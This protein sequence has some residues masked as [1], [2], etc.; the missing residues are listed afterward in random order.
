MVDANQTIR[1]R[2]HG[3]PCN[4]MIKMKNKNYHTFRHFNKGGGV[5]WNWWTQTAPLQWNENTLIY[6]TII[7]Y[8][9]I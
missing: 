4:D 5:K 6:Y 2:S 1:Y 7:G 3:D 8:F 9:A